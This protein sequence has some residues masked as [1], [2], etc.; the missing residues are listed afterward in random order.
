MPVDSFAE[1]TQP[2]PGLDASDYEAY[3]ERSFD[4]WVTHVGETI[5]V[6]GRLRLSD[7]LDE[8]RVFFVDVK[9]APPIRI[10]V[11]FRDFHDFNLAYHC[12]T[13]IQLTGTGTDKAGKLLIT[14]ISELKSLFGKKP[15]T[16]NG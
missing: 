12:G 1:A 4:S 10:E 13:P 6:Q 16:Q 5:T 11:G 7:D 14:K 2:L 9:D 8:A 3:R 15:G